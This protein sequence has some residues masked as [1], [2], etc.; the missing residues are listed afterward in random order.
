MSDIDMTVGERV[1]IRITEE[2]LRL[3]QDMMDNGRADSISDVIR[4]ALEE[5]LAKFYSPE[6]VKKLT[7]DLPK[8]SV[9]EL[10]SLI[11]SGNAISIDDA[12]RDAVREYTRERVRSKME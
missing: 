11:K 5:Y 8:G 12:I 7:V 9:M 3:I 2:Q 1:T 6:N 4:A 10:E